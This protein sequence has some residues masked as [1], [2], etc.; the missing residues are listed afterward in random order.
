M[1]PLTLVI[2]RASGTFERSDG[3]ALQQSLKTH[4]AVSDVWP[5]DDGLADRIRDAKPE[6]I[7]IAGG[8]GTIHAVTDLVWQSEADISLLPLPLGT[9]NLLV[10]RLYGDQDAM[11]LL[12]K[13][14]AAPVRLVRPGLA[15]DT[16]FL[17]AA[18]LGFPTTLARAREKLRDPDGPPPFPSFSRRVWASLQQAFKPRMHYRTDATTP[19]YHRASGLYLDLDALD[20]DDFSLVQLHWREL[21]DMALTGLSLFGTDTG[22]PEPLSRTHELIATARRPLAV[23]LDGE[24]SFV[25]GPLTFRRADRPL[26][27]LDCR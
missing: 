3:D 20:D 1:A 12:D 26:K 9:A 17:V 24:P 11:A 27:I 16:P 22:R 18:A 7:A 14:E 4:P 15:G 23:M 19:G 6:A 5:L 8:D 10:K 2:N 21:R 25:P 13:A